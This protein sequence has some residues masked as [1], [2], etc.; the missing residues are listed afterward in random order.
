MGVPPA[1]VED[2][3][4][5]LSKALKDNIIISPAPRNMH[6]LRNVERRKGR[7][8]TLLRRATELPGGS[9]FVDAAQ[10]ANSNSFA[11]VS[12]NHR[13]STVNAASARCP[14]S[15]AAEQVAIALALLDDKHEHIVT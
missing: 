10:Y 1:K 4:Q 15:C 6:P 5:G 3:Y 8:A 12:I 14:S 7:A 11:A 2:T 9:C 13:G